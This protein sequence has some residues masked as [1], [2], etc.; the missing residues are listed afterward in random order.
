[1]TRVRNHALRLGASISIAI[2][3][4]AMPATPAHADIIL[5]ASAGYFYD[6]N[7]PNALNKADRREDSAL[8]VSARAG[9]G[10]QL[11]TNTGISASVLLRQA[12]YFQYEGLTN[13]AAG[14]QVKLRHKFGLGSNT[15]WLSISGQALHLDYRYDYRDG[16]SYDAAI[17]VGKRLNDRLEL[18]GLVSYDSYVADELQP[19]IL[20]GYSTDAYDISGWTLGIR[21][22]IAMSTLDYLSAAYARRNGTVTAVTPPDFEVLEYSDAIARDTVFEPGWVAYRFADDVDTDL[23]SLSWTH[24][25]GR[26]ASMSLSYVYSTTLAPA[27]LGSYDSNVVSL[28]VVYNL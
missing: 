19:T 10:H 4:A 17:A 22:G 1:M 15:P 6:D 23:F 14:A 25:F 16:W 5:D 24:E 11:T 3:T 18:N 9:V 20:P 13:F 28:R 12:Q 7:L 27:D 21:A 2:G 8:T 26:H